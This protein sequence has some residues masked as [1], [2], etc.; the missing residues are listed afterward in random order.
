MKW[1]WVWLALAAGVAVVGIAVYGNQNETVIVDKET[2]ERVVVKKRAKA[3][4]SLKGELRERVDACLAEV[5]PIQLSKGARKELDRLMRDRGL[6]TLSP[7][8]G[9]ED[10]GIAG[11]DDLMAALMGKDESKAAKVLRGQGHKIVIVPRDL[12]GAVD[13]DSHVLARLAHHSH[14]EHFKLRYVMAEAF[15]YSIRKVPAGLKESTGA[16]L[17]AGLRARLAGTPAPRQKWTPD[18]IR[19]IGVM[20][21]QGQTLAMRHSVGKNVESTLDDLAARLRRRW[22]REVEPMGMGRLEDRLDDIRLEVH[23]VVERAPVEPRDRLS[24][25]EL[26]EMGI[27]GAMFQHH[28][29][30]KNRKFSY[31]PGSELV[32]NSYRDVDKMLR[33]MVEEGGWRD[34]RPWEDRQTELDLIRTVHFMEREVGGGAGAI[35]LYRGMPQVSMESMTDEKIRSMLVNGGEWWVNNLLPDNS[36]EYKY[37]PTQNRKSTDYNEVRHILGTRD[38]ADVWRYRQ[39]PRY[40]K[41]SRRSMEWLMQYAIYGDQPEDPRAN[42]PH[43]SVNSMLFRYPSVAER[44]AGLTK[45]QPNQKLG[46]VAV[47]LLGWIAYAD[48]SGDKQFDADIRKMGEYV[49]SQQNEAGKF[50]AYNVPRNHSYFGNKNDIVPGEAALALGMLAEYF[51]EPRWLDSFPKFL[52]YYTPWFRER[53]KRQNP[54]GRWPHNTY[55]NNDRLDLVQFGPWSVMASKQYYKMRGDERAAD[56]GLEVA[57]WMIDNYQWSGDRSPWPDYV[58]GY[59]KMPTELPAMQTFCYS[60][61]TAAA[62][63]IASRYKPENKKYE[64]ATHEAI[65][66]LDVMQFDMRDSYFVARPDMVFGGVKY[67]MNENKVRTDYVGHG[68]ST[69]SQFLDAREWDPAYDRK[70]PDPRILDPIL[71]VPGDPE[72]GTITELTQP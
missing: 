17:L 12:V 43:P 14:L 54:Y 18:A 66:F 23:V 21:T 72:A 70:L 60:E 6:L 57:D 64:T 19:L 31:I 40:L 41:A 33:R 47:A 63:T 71:R 59:Y 13:N 51:D 8:K 5:E 9:F 49:L 52:D 53:A 38:L 44:R 10:K 4:T 27:D 46:T 2:G 37:W 16:D 69:L 55:S 45:K 29:G 28:E 62:Y 58:G 11:K 68:L 7:V 39:D 30:V 48:A 3:C 50:Q 26:F 34:K 67:T 56:F 22:E 20:R 42:L 36:F 65:R 25:F 15:I 35:E 24:I 1:D 32:A 61:G